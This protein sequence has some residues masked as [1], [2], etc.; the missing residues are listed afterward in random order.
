MLHLVAKTI[1]LEEAVL[2]GRVKLR[3]KVHSRQEY[4]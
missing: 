3:K 4:R 1:S 2:V